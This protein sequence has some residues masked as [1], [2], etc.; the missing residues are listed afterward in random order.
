MAGEL[1]DTVLWCSSWGS[2][3]AS[4]ACFGCRCG[5]LRVVV[6]AVLR[7][8]GPS[9]SVVSNGEKGVV[10]RRVSRRDDEIL[11]A[12]RRG[13]AVVAE[14]FY[15]RIKPIVDRTVRR[16]IGR[17]RSRRRGSGSNRPRSAHRVVA[18][19]PGRVS[20][21]RLGLRG[22]GARRLQA[23]PAPPARAKHLRIGAGRR[24]RA[25]GQPEDA[26]HRAKSL[27]PRCGQAGG[28]PS[29][30]ACGRTVPGPSCF[31]TSAAIPSMKSPTS[32]A[33]RSPPPR[34]VWCA[35]AAICT[36]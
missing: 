6:M 15:W 17:A 9:L 32:V 22:G 3:R 23:H 31:T 36:S 19:L 34:V 26:R 20:A 28:R 2:F 7:T 1:A 24:R 21:G 29:D 8:S 30:D 11:E 14:D 13:D 10:E 16:L 5:T 18:L 12:V 25:L 35:G 27:A 33:S 4:S